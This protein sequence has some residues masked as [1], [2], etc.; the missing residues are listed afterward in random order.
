[1][2]LLF[3]TDVYERQLLN[4]DNPDDLTRLPAAWRQVEVRPV[5]FLTLIASSLM[6]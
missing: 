3:S 1:M 5:V 4:A 2:P 6:L